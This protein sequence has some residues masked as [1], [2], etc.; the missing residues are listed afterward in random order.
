MKFQNPR[1][2]SG[3][4]IFYDFCSEVAH[5]FMLLRDDV[6]DYTEK[7]EKKEDKLNKE[8][9]SYLFNLDESIENPQFLLKNRAL[10]GNEDYKEFLQ[11][12]RLLSRLIHLLNIKNIKI[13]TIA[14]E[15]SALEGTGL[16]GGF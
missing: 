1:S 9:I 12:F 6:F 11:Y 10:V 14:P 4:D 2:S 3:R 16:L 7:K 8:K 15:F 13:K 5:L